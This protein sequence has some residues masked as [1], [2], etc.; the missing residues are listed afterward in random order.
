MFTQNFVNLDRPLTEAHTDVGH[1]YKHN[2]TGETFISITTIFKLLDKKE[3]VVH[4]D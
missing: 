4:N 3:L 1:F 2:D